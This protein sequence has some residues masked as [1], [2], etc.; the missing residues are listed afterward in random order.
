[1]GYQR[2]YKSGRLMGVHAL[3]LGVLAACGAPAEPTPAP[4]VAVQP[5]VIPTIPPATATPVPIATEKPT[6]VATEPPPSS[7]SDTGKVVEIQ[8]DEFSF[9]ATA[10]TFTVGTSYRFVV[11]NTGAVPHEWLIEN[12]EES[13]DDHAHTNHSDLVGNISE[14]EFGPG[15]TV[16][17]EVV[18]TAKG[19][20]EFACRL[21]G[22]YEAGMKQIIEVTE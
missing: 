16:I 17:R 5:T 21:P 8:G 9:N 18:F 10:T 14:A 1:M 19:T 6:P 15:A 7:E 22:H 4:A 20:Y 11:T 2:I 3:L 12:V 13:N